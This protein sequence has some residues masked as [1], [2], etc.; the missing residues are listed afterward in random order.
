MSRETQL[1]VKLTDKEAQEFV[2]HAII[3]QFQ[4]FYGP[5]SG[6]SMRGRVLAS[7]SGDRIR[8]GELQALLTRR[9]IFG[10]DRKFK[11]DPKKVVVLQPKQSLRKAVGGA[12]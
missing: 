7:P 10:S 6:W 11:K 3:L 12:E 2:W 5:W 9:F 4:D 8:V 1:P